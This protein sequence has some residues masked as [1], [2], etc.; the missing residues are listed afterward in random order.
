MRCFKEFIKSLPPLLE[1]YPNL[2]VQIAGE[3]KIC[4]GGLNPSKNTTWGTWAKEYLASG[5]YQK[6]VKWL[7][8]LSYDKYKQWLQRSWCH[9]YLSQPVCS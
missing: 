4:Y 1:K 5:N 8:N 3:D 6:R 9:V 2:E 7:G